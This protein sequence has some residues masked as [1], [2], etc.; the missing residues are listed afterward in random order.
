MLT[1]SSSGD[2][3]SLMTLLR[4]KIILLLSIL[5][6]NLGGSPGFLFLNSHRRVYWIM[7]VVNIECPWLVLF[8]VQNVE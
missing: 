3:A 8:V 6:S 5:I 4:M 7:K 2:V 1:I